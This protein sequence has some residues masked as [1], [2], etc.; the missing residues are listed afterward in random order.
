MNTIKLAMFDLDGTLFDTSMSNFYS[1]YDAVRSLCGHEIDKGF[2][3]T[4][5]YSRNYRSFLPDLGVG[6][7]DIK[8]VHDLKIKLY[9]GYLDTIKVNEKL[10]YIAKLLRNEGCKLAIVTTGSKVNTEE[11]LSHFGFDD[12]FDD[13]VLKEA[14][15]VLTK[16]QYS[17]LYCSFKSDF[18][19]YEIAEKMGTTVRAVQ[20][21]RRRALDK[22][23]DEY[24]SLYEE[25]KAFG[26]PGLVSY[27]YKR[28]MKLFE[29]CKIIFS[30]NEPPDASSIQPNTSNNDP[31]A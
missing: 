16:K 18:D 11:I 14:V 15:E 7:S 17:V 20:D 4:K 21:L 25:A 26:Y 3:L 29:Q 6:E 30:Q 28:I 1:Y 5:C 10:I 27:N 19:T 13:P 23:R 31:A 8:A 9:S 24:I 12:L 22:L 2:F